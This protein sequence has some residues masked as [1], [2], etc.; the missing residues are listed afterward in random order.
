MTD[1]SAP[2]LFGKIPSHGDFVRIHA[3]DAAARALALWL[4]EG[5]EAARRASAPAGGEPARF[6]FS[7]PGAATALVGVLAGSADRV[8]RQFPLAVFAS[9][10]G[11]GLAGVFPLVPTGARSFLEGAAGLLAEAG[12]LSP[13]DLPAR[14]QALP[15]LR[16]EPLTR[17]GSGLA[18]L[19]AGAPAR[20]VLSRLFGD[21]SAGQHWYAL[22]CFRSACQPVREREP[23]GLGVVLDC[24]AREDLDRFLWLDLARRALRWGPPSFFWTG[25]RLLVALGAPPAALFAGLWNPGHRDGKLWPLTTQRPEAVAAARKALG[26]AV[27][28]VLERPGASVAELL[29]TLHR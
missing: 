10:E 26:P 20:D 7:P 27:L 11:R 15:Q 23:S 22:H 9:A 25:G 16:H 19:A 2:G 29:V 14:L 18:G 28:E 21:L 13:Q 1:F 17:D 3:A 24:P 5:S 4:E 8:G 6:L 12:R